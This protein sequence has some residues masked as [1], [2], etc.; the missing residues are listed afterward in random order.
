[1]P[2]F[3]ARSICKFD[4][5]ESN[6]I[7]LSCDERKETDM[8]VDAKITHT[9][10]LPEGLYLQMFVP[11]V[12][13]EIFSIKKTDSC[14]VIFA[15]DDSITSK[16]RKLIYATLK[17]VADFMGERIAE[18]EIVFKQLFCQEKGIEGISF[19]DCTRQEASDFI[20]FLLEFAF[21]NDVPLQSEYGIDRAYNINRY[22][23]LCLKYRKCCVCGKKADLHHDDAIGRGFNRNKV[24]DSNKRKMALC[25]C[26]HQER[27]AIGSTAFNEK[28]HVYGIIWNGDEKARW[29]ESIDEEE[30]EEEYREYAADEKGDGEDENGN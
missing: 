28:Y 18:T 6:F 16:Q 5:N 9:M 7:Y 8:I 24:D 26:H 30:A 4:L 2:I 19:K 11:L 23:E 10:C 17:D 29:N 15:E 3:F 27:H 25:R 1:M 14:E 20:D 12:T 13:D 22:L 21:Y